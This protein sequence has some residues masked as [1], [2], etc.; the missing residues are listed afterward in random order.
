M[1]ND[2]AVLLEVGS[3]CMRDILI[4]ERQ[5]AVFFINQVN[6]GATEVGK[7]RRKLTADDTRTENHN[8]FGEIRQAGNTVTGQDCFFVDRY[9][10]QITRTTT[11]RQHNMI[12]MNHLGTA[13]L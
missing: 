8:T 10:R 5:N 6:L 12:G 7:N 13:V 11:N 4:L 2:D 9:F 1:V 3:E